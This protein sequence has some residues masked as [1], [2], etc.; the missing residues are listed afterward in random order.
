MATK[1]VLTVDEGLTEQEVNDLRYLFADALA[2]FQT[3]RFPVRDY[4]ERRYPDN[5]IAGC[6]T[7]DEKTRQVQSRVTLAQK[8]HNPV[9]QLQVVPEPLGQGRPKCTNTATSKCYTCGYNIPTECDG[10]A[11]R[12]LK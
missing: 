1:I 7:W 9:L 3:A 11:C 6:F 8:M 5:G 4:V 2:E 10:L 12:G